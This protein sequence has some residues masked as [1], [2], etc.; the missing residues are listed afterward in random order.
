M[1][2]TYLRSFFCLHSGSFRGANVIGETR[3]TVSNVG[4]VFQW[5]GYGLKI[6]IPRNSLPNGCEY[7]TVTI[8]A[9]LTGQFQLDPEDSKL[10]SPV[11]WISSTERF[12]QPVTIEIQHCAIIDDTDSI[13]DLRFVTAKRNQPDLP[14]KFRSLDGGVFTPH[15]THGSISLTHFC[16]Q[17]C[18]SKRSR[19]QGYCAQF[20]TVSKGLGEWRVYFVITKN[21]EAA[22]TVRLYDL[23]DGMCLYQFIQNCVH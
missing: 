11:F 4:G 14:Y 3:I 6:H 15:S 1:Y 16:A 5:Q 18:T 7:C 8:T 20:F 22:L 21:L 2:I 23:L 19:P 10:V 17:A 9:S 12:S 13:S